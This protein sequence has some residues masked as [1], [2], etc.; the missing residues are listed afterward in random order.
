MSLYGTNNYPEQP[1][2]PIH[3]MVSVTTRTRS[4]DRWKM[5]TTNT[6]P[7]NLYSTLSVSSDVL[8]DYLVPIWNF[9]QRQRALPNTD[10]IAVRYSIQIENTTAPTPS[11]GSLV[12][13]KMHYDG[14]LTNENYDSTETLQAVIE[15]TLAFIK[16]L[17]KY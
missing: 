9:T 10:S 6:E 15:N 5:T 4:A 14:Q 8:H 13:K 16:K 12:Q 11:K 2:A 17:A 1:N 7:F 3:V